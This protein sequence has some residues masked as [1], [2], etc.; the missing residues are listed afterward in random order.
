MNSTTDQGQIAPPSVMPW[1]GE[2]MVPNLSDV[3]TELFHWQRYLFFR[4]WYVGKK[5]VDA[6]SGEGY[7]ANYASV[8]AEK[9]VGIDIAKDAVEHAGVRYP[10]VQFL[11]DDVT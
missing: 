4:P 1:T 7:G 9:V 5:V 10:H 3:A 11:Q 2:R 8:F 6:A